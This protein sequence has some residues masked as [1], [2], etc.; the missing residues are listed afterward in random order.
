MTYFYAGAGFVLGWA[1]GLFLISLFLKKYS[2]KEL[3]TD[4][5]LH[6]KYGMVP[7]IFA[8]IGLWLGLQLSQSF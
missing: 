1:F 4:K 5:S 7:W 8:A 2:K 6:Y 3:I